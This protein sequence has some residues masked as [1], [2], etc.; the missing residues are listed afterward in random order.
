MTRH[1]TGASE[2][3]GGIA[4]SVVSLDMCRPTATGTTSSQATVV[5]RVVPVVVTRV[6]HEVVTRVVNAAAEVVAVVSTKVSKVAPLIQLPQILLTD[7]PGREG[8]I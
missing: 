6:T 2:D 7:K 5:T 3:F 8:E 1:E 4:I